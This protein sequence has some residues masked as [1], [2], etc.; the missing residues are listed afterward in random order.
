MTA[1][2]QAF[3]VWPENWPAVLLFIR[4]QTQW[5]TGINGLVGL[6]YQAV[7]SVGSL[8]QMADL[9]SVLED[10]QV[11]EHTILSEGKQS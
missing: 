11:I 3:E 2:P 6:D 9:P 10:L 7:L 8:Y 1:P 5:R 4:C